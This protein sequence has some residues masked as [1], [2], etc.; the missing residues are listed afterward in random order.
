[1]HREGTKP[2]LCL[3]YFDIAGI[4]TYHSKSQIFVI[5]KLQ[6]AEMESDIYQGNTIAYAEMGSTSKHS[7]GAL[8]LG[9]RNKTWSWPGS[10]SVWSWWSGLSK[11]G[12]E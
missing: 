4:R 10:L 6:M 9:A 3:K 5:E 11:S 1:M 8:R 7:R 2:T 12:P